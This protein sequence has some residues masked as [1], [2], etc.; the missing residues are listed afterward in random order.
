MLWIDN[1]IG[2]MD[3]IFGLLVDSAAESNKGSISD[4]SCLQVGAS[5]L[6]LV[7]TLMEGV[8]MAIADMAYTNAKKTL[9]LNGMAASLIYRTLERNTNGGEAIY[10]ISAPRAHLAMQ[11]VS[12]LHYVL[13]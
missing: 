11:L 4:V 8:Q 7:G 2:V 12:N 6:R 13:L 3:P 10:F 9:D 5:L 1:T